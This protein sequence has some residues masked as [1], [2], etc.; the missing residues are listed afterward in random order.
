MLLTYFLKFIK[1]NICTEDIIQQQKWKQNKGNTW[2]SDLVP[3]GSIYFQT[4]YKHLPVIC[5]GVPECGGSFPLASCAPILPLRFLSFCLHPHEAFTMQLLIRCCVRLRTFSCPL[6]HLGQQAACGETNT[7]LP[8]ALH[9]SPVGDLATAFG[10]E[11]TENRREKRHKIRVK[12]QIYSPNPKVLGGQLKS[13]S[14]REI[15]SR[16]RRSVGDIS[17]E[18]A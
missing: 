15:P 11:E 1:V 2:T 10:K 13:V 17:S 14:N 4:F 7:R 9:R 5:S 12:I 6:F 8:G 18:R 3:C 16:H